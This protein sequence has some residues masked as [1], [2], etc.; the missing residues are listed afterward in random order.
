MKIKNKVIYFCVIFLILTSLTAGGQTEQINVTVNGTAVIFDQQPYV[1]AQNRTMVPVRFVAEELGCEVDWDK[2]KQ[3][4]RITNDT[5]HIELVL[6]ENKA[7]V[8]DRLVY[9]DTSSEVENQR[10]MVPVRFISET[11]GASVVWHQESYEVEIVMNQKTSAELIS[12][13]VYYVSNDGSDS[14]DGLSEATAFR[15][16]AHAGEQAL[17]PG[18][19]LLLRRGDTYRERLYVQFSGNEDNWITYGAYGSGDRPRILGS[20]ALSE[21][22]QVSGNIWR[23][24][25][26]V[27]NPFGAYYDKGEVFFETLD[28]QVDWGA[29]QE[30]QIISSLEKE[31]DWTYIDG[32][33][34]VFASGNPSQVYKSVEAPQRNNCI[35]FPEMSGGTFTE[36]DTVE[37]I[38]IQD[39]EVM[40]AR[41]QGIYV[42]YSEIVAR[43]LH[44]TGC[45]IGYIGIKGGSS[46]YGIASWYS[47]MTIDYNVIHDC[48]R[49]GISINTYTDN[50]EDMSVSNVLI[51]HNYIYNGYHTTGPDISSISG[52][53]HHF[54]DFT[55]SNNIFDDTG[56]EHI[57]ETSNVIY[58]QGNG[59]VYEDFSIYN[60][61]IYGATSRAMLIKDID[62]V[63][64]WHNTIYGVH[65][66]ARPY[67]MVTFGEATGIDF[68]K[69]I[70]HGTL[71]SSS[72]DA[73]CVLDENGSSF[74]ARDYNLYYQ[75][76]P[77]QQFTGSS[78]IGGYPNMSQFSQWQSETAWDAHA[79]LPANPLFLRV[80]EDLRVD[81]ISPA[82]GA[83]VYIID[84]PYDLLGN[85]RDTSNPTIGAYEYIEVK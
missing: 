16:L 8:N 56:I 63:N 60:N 34:Y 48:G 24:E 54:Y 28:N 67:G 47:D 43:G 66:E 36:E 18:D 78:T 70:I 77:K 26:E 27:E 29:Y 11:L 75:D 50:T 76:D 38:R 6:G 19:A 25:T 22:T 5:T 81:S 41:R 85:K 42:G 32:Q 37:Y 74:V 9:F 3:Q 84:V 1:N 79:P 49:R 62:G 35:Y 69:N 10:T 72:F 30:D 13:T 59:N 53:G 58:I 55:I 80:Y 40:Y 71:P 44:I 17:N 7:L 39:L 82:V 52:L 21:W 68:R 57:E 46:A 2:E 23:S 83:G 73:Y 12:G 4:V 65:P 14:N 64:I 61:V 20:D 15:T 31:F 33:V 45:H 51:D